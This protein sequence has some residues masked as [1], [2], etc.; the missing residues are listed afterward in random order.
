M[1]AD[2]GLDGLED[3]PDRVHADDLHRAGLARALD[4][5]GNADG[6]GGIAA[7]VTAQIGMPLKHGRGLLAG[8]VDVVVVAAAV[9]HRDARIP[10]QHSELGVVALFVVGCRWKALHHGHL[11]RVPDQRGEPL[12]GNRSLLRKVIAHAGDARIRR[13]RIE[14]H[15]RRSLLA[16]A[17]DRRHV[18]DRIH[19]IHSDACRAA[20]SHTLEDFVLLMGI[21]AGG[22]HVVHGD[23]DAKLRAEHR[24]LHASSLVNLVE[25]GMSDFGD[26][27]E[28]QRVGHFFVRCW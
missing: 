5:R 18:A 16:Y 22:R 17:A 23:L 27:H 15:Q 6:A 11:A 28:T 4:G 19:R 24:G 9:N 25:P 10:C 1:V 2:A 7:Q 8:G 12:G 14:D 13:G 21:G 3:G 20:A 26:D